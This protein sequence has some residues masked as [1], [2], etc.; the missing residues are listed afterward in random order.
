VTRLHFLTA[1]ES[2]GPGLVGII[3]GLPAGIPI[4]PSDI[5]RDLARRQQGYG[6]GGRMKIEK[7]TAEILAGI[8]FALTLGSPVA[9]LIRNGDLFLCSEVF[10]IV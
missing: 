1:G 4:E 9:L 2:H 8:R 6:R 5:D 10:N 7:D 3:E